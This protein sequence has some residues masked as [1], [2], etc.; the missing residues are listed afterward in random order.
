[1]KIFV[2]RMPLYYLLYTLLPL[3]A[4]M[5]I[6]VLIFHL[7]IG[8]RASYGVTIL[9][10]ISVFLLVLSAKLPEKSND[11]PWVGLSFIVEFLL[12][13]LAL[14]LAEFNAHIALGANHP[15][16]AFLMN[17]IYCC[18]R[19]NKVKSENVIKVDPDME[20][21]DVSE[22]V[23]KGTKHDYCEQWR[24]LARVLDVIF[25]FIFIISIVVAPLIVAS[26]VLND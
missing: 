16:P 20:L 24:V 17:I 7:D 22:E 12:L 3:V 13:C 6:M 5:F 2:K 9:L 23:I 1:M 18:N 11:L 21:E 8:Q 14:P 25:S 15:P 26:I 4:L 10:S 19:A